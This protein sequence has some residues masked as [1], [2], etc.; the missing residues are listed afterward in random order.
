M[1]RRAAVA[2]FSFWSLLASA[3][4]WQVVTDTTLGQL[5]LDKTSVRTEG[6]FTAAV[7]V[8]RFKGL[9]RLS[10]P[11]NA[12]F[13]RRYDDVLVDC[14]GK[15]LGIVTSRFFEDEKLASSFSLKAS[16]VK[17]KPSA[18]GTMTET[19][20]LAVCALKPNQDL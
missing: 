17:F 4:D 18:P 19:V 16:D 2:V 6:K 8:Y 13:N 10:T 12:V 11:P 15:S 20:I 1:Y 14:S 5:Q 3:A 9:Q 7:L